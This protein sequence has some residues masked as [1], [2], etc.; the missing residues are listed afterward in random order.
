MNENRFGL[1][2]TDEPPQEGEGLVEVAEDVTLPESE[3]TKRARLMRHFIE[4]QVLGI[5]PV[6]D[7][8]ETVDTF[9]GMPAFER[10]NLLYEKILARQATLKTIHEQKISTEDPQPA[11][12]VEPYLLAEIKALWADPEVQQ[13]FLDRYSEARVDAKV[14]RLSDLGTSFRDLSIVIALK[15][16]QFERVTRDL[17]LGRFKRADQ[18][19]VARSKASRLARELI[20]KRQTQADIVALEG[21]PKI[22]ENTDSAA[23][24]HYDRLVEMH[25][26]DKR[27]NFVW[28]P[29]REQ[30]Y[31]RTIGALQNGRWPVLKGESGTGKSELAVA[32]ARALTGLNPTYIT[33]GPRTGERDLIMDKEIDPRTGGSFDRFKPLMQAATGFDDSRQETPGTPQGRI[34]RLD[35]FNRL[36]QAGPAYSILKEARQLRPGSQFHGHQVLPG[37][38]AIGTANPPGP[39]YP[40]RTDPDAAMRRE[41]AE[42]KV[43][44]PPQTSADPELFEFILATLM[45]DHGHITV[46][47]QELAPAY[48]RQEITPPYHFSDADHRVVV[49][50]QKLV[51]DPTSLEHGFVWRLSFALRSLQ[52]AFNYGNTSD[53]PDSAL[54]YTIN[55]EGN[56]EI[57]NTGGELLTLRSSTVTSG[58]IASWMKGFHDRKQKDNSEFQTE[59]L[60]EWIQ[61]KLR[62]YIE[63]ADNEDRG[64]L[65]ALFAHFHLFD[66]AKS[67]A[68]AVP[69]VPK[70]IGYLSPRV[71][72]PL[73][74]EDPEPEAAPI[75]VKPPEAPPEKTELYETTELILEDGSRISVRPKA[76]TIP[77]TEKQI[78]LFPGSP[79]RLKGE[80]VAFAGTV[81]DSKRSD[82]NGRVVVRVNVDDPDSGLHRVLTEEEVAAEGSE[83]WPFTAETLSFEK[84]KASYESQVQ[85]LLETG[86]IE[87][88]PRSGELGV[89]GVDEQEHPIPS[90]AKVVERLMK[91]GETLRT[92][93]EQ[94]FT[95]LLLVPIAKPLGTRVE[96]PATS[97]TPERYTY[98]GLM[99]SLAELMRKTA[100]AQGEKLKAEKANPTDQGQMLDLNDNDPLYAWDKI[101]GSDLP[102]AKE[103]MIYYPKAF[104]AAKHGGMT[105]S[106]LLSADQND[107]WEILLT[108][109]LAVIP[110]EAMGTPVGNRPPIESKGRNVY[111]PMQSGQTIPSPHEYLAAIQQPEPTSPYQNESGLTL[112]AWIM[113]AI[114][115]L[116]ASGEVLDDF[117]GKG[118]ISWLLGNFLDDYVPYAYFN[119]DNHQAFLTRSYPDYRYDNCGVRA[120]VRVP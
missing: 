17:F 87:Q 109:D 20:E 30:I 33:C 19:S 114:H 95:E 7:E 117:Q 94:G 106:E 89:V 116:K 62:L 99:A 31:H 67:L 12:A 81:E 110:R 39:R 47:K 54:R 97:T 71:P 120:A 8:G 42:I 68:S 44:Y 72:R 76:L 5:D 14:Y 56:P 51:E 28:L 55:E 104:D 98:T 22:P 37:F 40:D 103:P 101:Q 108:Q 86:V 34:V 18:L 63:Q 107:G 16:R 84:L 80:K 70:D 26:Q 65:K 53:I 91:A 13:L 10:A 69:L 48:L 115:K 118:R 73:E 79:F 45:D 102:G 25:H 85:T 112:E 36:D 113:L 96:V 92:K 3:Q 83:F 35:E 52:D 60:T 43:D 4:H 32:A 66:P 58:E 9:T 49:G 88:L 105:K 1:P 82:L 90:F 93:V 15:E 24:I 46:A 41:I 75:P 21:L 11:E 59:S 78:Y 50:E 57:V 100:Q 64:K 6:L 2:G 61:Y 74:L 77:H 111:I 27:D 38:S 23:L 29:S 119:R